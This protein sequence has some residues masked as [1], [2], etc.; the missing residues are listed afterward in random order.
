MNEKKDGDKMSLSKIADDH[1]NIQPKHS[2]VN[3]IHILISIN[4]LP[5]GT[6]Q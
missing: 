4:N 2:Y 6:R 5:R 3:S 1:I